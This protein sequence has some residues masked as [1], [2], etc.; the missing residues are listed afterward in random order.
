[1]KTAVT[2]DLLIE[3]DFAIEVV[4]TFLEVFE[5]ANL[6]TLAH[7]PG[8][9]LGP[10]EQRKITSSFLTH[11]IQKI[12]DLKKHSWLVPSACK[13]LHI[14]CSTDLI[15]NVTRGLSQ[16]ISKCETP[17]QISY[18]LDDALMPSGGSIREKIFGSMVKNWSKKAFQQADE[19]WL[20]HEDYE[21]LVERRDSS[22]KVKV[23]P[24]FIRTQDF[25]V[26]PKDVFDHNYYVVNAES[27]D[28][29]SAKELMVLFA[30]RDTPYVFVGEDAHLSSLKSK[31]KE[32][33]FHGFKCNGELA[34]LFA[35]SRAVID[36]TERSFPRIALSALS[37]GR[38]V[39]SKTNPFYDN[40]ISD[41]A[42]QFKGSFEQA[43]NQMDSEHNQ[44]EPQDLHNSI[45]K[46]H[47]AKFKGEILRLQTT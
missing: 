46:F 28:E 19:I 6:Y 16:G 42:V 47:Q 10:V 35:A 43:L 33:L 8:E 36:L 27:I 2:T 38:P 32:G 13:K 30:K 25:P 31:E 15:L 14:P 7:R 9:I 3:K 17:K 18:L 1:M 26:G 41:N 20:A 22:V 21:L 45:N 4:Q 29:K 40:K 11:K 5:E 39:I 37:S 34:P 24:P 44:Y 12:E 23:V